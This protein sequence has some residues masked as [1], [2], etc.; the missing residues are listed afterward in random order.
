MR[1]VYD[2]EAP[3]PAGL[4]PDAPDQLA[5][6]AADQV[7]ELDHAIG[8]LVHREPEQRVRPERREPHL[9]ALLEAVVLDHGVRVVKGGDERR[10]PA[11]GKRQLDS[12]G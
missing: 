10:V 8:Q 1:G 2:R 11:V 9:D 4:V 6:I 12:P 5:G 7:L 3:L